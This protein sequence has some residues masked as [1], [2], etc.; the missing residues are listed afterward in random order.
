MFKIKVQF[1]DGK[2][3]FHQLSRQPHENDNIIAYR[4]VNTSGG[5][6]SGYRL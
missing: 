4:D 2:A 1:F 5:I 6:F 3:S